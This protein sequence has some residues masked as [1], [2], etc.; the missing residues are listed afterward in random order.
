[1]VEFKEFLLR[2]FQHIRIGFLFIL[3]EFCLVFIRYGLECYGGGF[4]AHTL[5]NVAELFAGVVVWIGNAIQAVLIVI[6]YLP[7]FDVNLV[8][9]G[10][11]HDLAVGEFRWRVDG[12]FCYDIVCL[13]TVSDGYSDFVCSIFCFCMFKECELDG[14]HGKRVFYFRE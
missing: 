5:Q 3:D 7:E 4:R 13:R 8:G 2:V 9:V 6:E 10:N 12:V 11:L 1:M 14:C